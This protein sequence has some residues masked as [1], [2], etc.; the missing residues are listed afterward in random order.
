MNQKPIGPDPLA[1]R[2]AELEAELDRSRPT[3]R[4]GDSHREWRVRIEVQSPD[5]NSC[6]QDRYIEDTLVVSSA[7]TG[8]ELILGEVEPMLQ[9]VVYLALSRIAALTNKSK[10]K[11][12]GAFLR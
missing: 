10:E 3:W 7:L 1:S 5:G 6:R 9:N 8:R 11:S 4:K 2:V 12:Y